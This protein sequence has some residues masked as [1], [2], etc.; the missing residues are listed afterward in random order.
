MVPPM[1][2]P[3]RIACSTAP[4]FSTGSTPGSAM[5][6]AEA[7]VFAS[8]PNAVEAA[9]KILL[10][11]RSCAWVSMPTTTSQATRL[12]RFAAQQLAVPA[13]VDE[14]RL[15]VGPRTAL[16]PAVLGRKPRGVADLAPRDAAAPPGETQATLHR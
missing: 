4:R 13:A 14:E 7:W 10:R 1:A 12:P 15:E 11:V 16:L 9:E 3:K 2:R 5:S 8:A 6:T